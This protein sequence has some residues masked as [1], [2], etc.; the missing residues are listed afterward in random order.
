MRT[1]RNQPAPAAPGLAWFRRSTHLSIPGA[2]SAAAA[3]PAARHAGCKLA[4][5]SCSTLVAWPRGHRAERQTTRP[6]APRIILR[7]SCPRQRFAACLR[8]PLRFVALAGRRAPCWR[9]G[10]RCSTSACLGLSF[11]MFRHFF[12]R[13]H[14]PL[15]RVDRGF[16]KAAF[17]KATF[18][19]PCGAS[20]LCGLRRLTTFTSWKFKLLHTI[21]QRG[22]ALLCF[23]FA[24]CRR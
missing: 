2:A 15:R 14:A 5:S 16:R 17:L 7:R 24:C 10:S 12:R 13:R 4:V 3:P 19:T 1:T 6:P 8:R 21:H 18:R 23:G 11:R 20:L 9:L 22:I